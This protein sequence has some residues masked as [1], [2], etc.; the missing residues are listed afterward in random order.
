MYIHTYIYT[1]MHTIQTKE[2]TKTSLVHS[3]YIH[4]HTHIHTYTIQAKGTTK[5]SLGRTADGTFESVKIN[6]V[7]YAMYEYVSVFRRVYIIH[8][9]CMYV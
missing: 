6:Q 7:I 5:T 2:T 3:I 1:N 8:G 4:T 9:V